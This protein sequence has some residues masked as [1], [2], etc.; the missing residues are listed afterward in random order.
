VLIDVCAKQTIMKIN[1]RVTR[2]EFREKFGTS[3][4]CLRYLSEQKWSGGYTCRKC[5]YGKHGNGKKQHGRRCSRC[6]YD[7]SSTS[8]TLFHK[9]K[10][11]IC[12]AFEMT[13]DIVTGK[14]GA[15]SIWLAEKYGIKQ[16]AAWLFRQKVQITMKSSKQ[17]PL[18]N[19]V[20]VDE[21]EIGTPKKGEPGRSAS[22]AKVRIVIAL[23][24][25]D[26]KPGRGYAKIIED[27]SSKSLK[28]IF[29]EHIQ[30]D[31]SVVTDGWSGYNPIRKHFPKLEQRLSDKGQ[32]FTM[33]HIQIRNFK[34]WLR[35]VHSYC[36]KEYLHR[37]I[38]E[39]FYRFN[40]LN[41]RDTIF[42][43]LLDRMVRVKSMAYKSIRCSAT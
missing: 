37:Y 16:M 34:N 1:K 6:G 13:F 38:D 36:N 42:E 23:E 4:Q 40:R 24:Y 26:G 14:K 32:N 22:K 31:A 43:K 19:E 30:K 7:E 5:G 10:F 17:H 11:D 27:Y 18:E 39:Y 3:D 29:D 2:Q 21:F 41:F 33:L 8:H 9:V 15:N 35:G 25:R 28:P 20:H 12:K